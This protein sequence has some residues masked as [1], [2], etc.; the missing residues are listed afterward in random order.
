MGCLDKPVLA[1]GGGTCTQQLYALYQA[2]Q[3]GGD[4]NCNITPAIP[5][6]AKAG[7]SWIASRTAQVGGIQASKFTHCTRGAAIF[8]VRCFCL[9]HSLCFCA[10][11]QKLQRDKILR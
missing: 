7:N 4:S 6:V 9:V 3:S 1:Q 10:E 2:S 5:K 8:P 11:L